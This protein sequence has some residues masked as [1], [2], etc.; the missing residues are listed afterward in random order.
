MTTPLAPFQQLQHHMNQSVIGQTDL[1][2]ALLIALLTNGNLLLEGMPGTAKTRA[3]KSLARAMRVDFGRIQ[4]TPDLLPSDITGTE[5]YQQSS[6]QHRLQFQ[7]G[8]VFNN[9]LLADEINRAPA[10]VQAA[11]L[12]AMEERQVTVAGRTHRLPELFLVLA[13]QNPLEQEGTYPLPEAQLDRF[14]MKVMLPYPDE[15]S[16]AA[17]IDLV[18]R[19][20]GSKG[21]TLALTPGWLELGRKAVQQVHVSE[22]ITQYIVGLVM[23]TREP[24][25][26]ADSPLKGWLLAGVSPRASVALHRCARAHAFLQGKRFVD[27]DDI[28]AVVHRVLRHRLL[29]S[30]DARIQ[31]VTADQIIDELLLQ[32][33]VA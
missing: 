26:L 27:P 16:E 15:Q 33:V 25:R 3:I 23:L 24:E 19:E 21:A 12:E 6:G 17:I 10:K 29:L 14:L 18:H 20:E 13:T 28:R 22:A 5:V 11:L 4:F 31:G 30:Y 8:P 7:P 32:A 9:L 1:T 2:Q